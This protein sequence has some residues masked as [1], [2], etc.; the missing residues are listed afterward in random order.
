M[1]LVTYNI[2]YGLGTDNRYDLDRTAAAV[3]GADIICLQ[4]VERFWK[5]SGNQDQVAELMRRI[6]DYYVVYGPNLDMHL[7]SEATGASS[8]RRQF[9]NAIFSRWPI[10]STRNFPLVKRSMMSQHSIQQGLLEAVI[11]TPSGAIRVYTTHLS[12]LCSQTRTPQID[13][14]MDIVERAPVEGGAWSGSHPEPESGWIEGEMPPMPDRMILT[15]DFN[16]DYRSAEYA[17]VVGPVSAK[18]GRLITPRGLADTW[19]AAGNAES[20]GKTQPA[21]P[22][23]IDHCFVSAWLSPRVVS[24]TIDTDANGSDHFPLWVAFEELG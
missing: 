16:F 23:R 10:L 24:A 8:A 15:G 14:I 12:H 21:K 7:S 2:R 1:Q 4:E 19:V 11:D 3:V 18:H 9:G 13:Q 22:H 6:P 5:R 20:A 17:A